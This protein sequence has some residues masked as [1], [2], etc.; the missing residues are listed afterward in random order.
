MRRHWRR[1][2]NRNDLDG[3]GGR[4]VWL[5]RGMGLGLGR[6]VD[7]ELVG[8]GWRG[9]R[10]SE[11]GAVSRSSRSSRSSARVGVNGAKHRGGNWLVAI[12]VVVFVV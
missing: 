9:V 8:H 3:L 11:H 5:G 7:I 4:V 12:V 6:I 2:A 1:W 10:G